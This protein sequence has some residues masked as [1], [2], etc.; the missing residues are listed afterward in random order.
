MCLLEGVVFKVRG[1]HFKQHCSRLDND[2]F[3]DP[4]E[5]Q[6]AYSMGNGW[7]LGVGRD[8]FREVNSSWAVQGFTSVLFYLGELGKEEL[9]N[10][11]QRLFS[12]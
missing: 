5:G 10:S 4:K 11:F 7:V 1:Q 12:N 2:T 3:E 9:R 6:Y 8:E